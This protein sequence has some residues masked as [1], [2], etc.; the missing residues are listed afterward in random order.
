MR[1]IKTVAELRALLPRAHPLTWYRPGRR[2]VVTDRMQRTS[3]TL[4]ARPGRDFAPDFH[5]QLSPAQMLR[6][7]VFEGKYLNDCV[8]EL[9]REW[10]AGALRRLSPGMPDPALNA[11]GVKSRLSLGQ[12][13][14]N[15]W[16][17]VAPG[18]PDVRGWFQWYCRYWLGRRLPEIDA[19]QIGRWRSFARHRA[20]VVASAARLGRR[21]PRSRDEKRQ[22]RPR[23]RQALLQWAYD[24]YV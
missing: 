10:Y 19:I 9:P 20:Q 8:L 5:P 11:F 16:L 3:Y 7:G 23:Q 6:R 21:Q 4:T 17:P 18:D 1:A 2:V 13:R 15:G 24:P 14:R 22:H 12:W